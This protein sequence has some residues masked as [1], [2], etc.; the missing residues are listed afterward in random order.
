MILRGNHKSSQSILNSSAIDKA[1]SKEIDH[2]WALHL[3]IESL[4]SIKNAGV[5]TLGVAEKFSINEMGER[6]IKIRVTHD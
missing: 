2:G 3:T 1:I 4:Q 5:V 6:Y